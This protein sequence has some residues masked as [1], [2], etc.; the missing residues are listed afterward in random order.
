VLD[1]VADRYG[2]FVQSSY[3]FGGGLSDAKSQATQPSNWTGAFVGVN[4]AYGSSGISSSLAGLSSHARGHQAAFEAPR[5]LKFDT[6]GSLNGLQAGY[7]YNNGRALFGVEA[8][9]QHAGVGGTASVTWGGGY[10]TTIDQNIRWFGTA[11]ARLGYF[12]SDDLLIF[13]TA[14]LA[15]GRTDLNAG[16]TQ[17]GAPCTLVDC[18][19]GSSSGLTKG[20]AS[21]LGV[22]YAIAPQLS[23]KGEY[24][25]VDLGSRT[26]TIVDRGLHAGPV[27]GANFAVKSSFDMNIVRAG[28]NYR[29]N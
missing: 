26:L 8:D 14:G 11:R 9:L 23:F 13:G 24:V 5:E 3:R 4:T 22:E 16:F 18:A 27:T 10:N 17:V 15:F 1:T 28:I 2:L 21:G 7:N 20:W 25:R 6:A 29:W 19:V 12:V